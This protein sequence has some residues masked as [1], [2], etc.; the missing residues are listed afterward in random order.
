MRRIAYEEI[1][2]YCIFLSPVE[3]SFIEQ[4]LDP[5]LRAEYAQKGYPTIELNRRGMYTYLPVKV[6]DTNYIFIRGTRP[7]KE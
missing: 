7:I 5:E 4:D 2:N 3:W 6:G 1:P